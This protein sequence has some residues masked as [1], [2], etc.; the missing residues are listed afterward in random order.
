MRVESQDA[1]H[2]ER[3]QHT[4]GQPGPRRPAHDLMQPQHDAEAPGK[5][6]ERAAVL[7]E[8]V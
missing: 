4:H 3:S 6:L 1:Q 8:P 2:R 5:Q 7:E